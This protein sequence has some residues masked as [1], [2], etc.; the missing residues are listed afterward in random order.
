MIVPRGVSLERTALCRKSTVLFCLSSHAARSITCL[1][2]LDN[3]FD[4]VDKWSFNAA[5]SITCV[6]TPKFSTHSTMIMVFQCR[7]QHYICWDSVVPSPCP[8]WAEKPFWKVVRFSR[9]FCCRN[10]FSRRKIAW[11]IVSVPCTARAAP[12]WKVTT[13]ECGLRAPMEHFPLFA[14]INIIAQISSFFN[15]ALRATNIFRKSFI[16]SIDV[17]FYLCYTSFVIKLITK[18]LRRY[19]K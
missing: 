14:L 15:N 19:G 3:V 13:V 2:T 7:T 9:R 1:G 10:A 11:Q 4:M 5:R 18:Y 12:L 16:V 17:I 6:G 8:T